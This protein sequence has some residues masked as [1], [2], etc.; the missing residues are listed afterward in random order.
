MTDTYRAVLIAHYSDLPVLDENDIRQD[1]ELEFDYVQ[2][3]TVQSSSTITSSPTVEGD[4]VAD[5]MYRNPRTMTLSGQFSTNGYKG[6]L[7]SST[8]R[9]TT[10]EEKF[11]E[12]QSKG[13]RCTIISTKKENN[14]SSSQFKIRENMYLQSISWTEKVN[15][16]EFNFT[17]EEVIAVTTDEIE[18][19]ENVLDDTLPALT[20]PSQSSAFGVIIDMND[21]DAIIDKVAQDTGLVTGEFIAVVVACSAGTVMATGLVIGTLV[22]SGPVGWVA[23]GAVGIG[24]GLYFLIKSLFGFSEA[25]KY[26]VEQFKYYK[27][28]DAKNIA[29]RERYVKFKGEIANQIRKLDDT[30]Q[31]YQL[32]EDKDQEC[33][34]MIDDEYWT[35]TFVRD[36][37]TQLYSLKLTNYNTG[38]EYPCPVLSTLTNIGDCKSNNA[39]TQTLTSGYY[40]Y[41]MSPVLGTVSGA[42]YEEKKKDLRNYM[43]VI[44]QFEPEEFTKMLEEIIRNAIL[45]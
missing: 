22:A 3:P 44:L 12:I 26:V 5:H 27:D 35:F 45:K 1:E 19:A 14:E 33:M 15:S 21:V 36:N 41:I 34:L 13:I 37:S 10:I 30:M 42:E 28:D 4:Y 43:I 2:S 18:Y 9:L 31:V 17:F 11:E 6:T 40:I 23:A 20:E 32:A 39:I 8:N 29:E 7:Y 25:N 24:V 38:K 16:L